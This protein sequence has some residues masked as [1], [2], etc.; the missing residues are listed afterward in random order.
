MIYALT[1][2]Q[3]NLL[4]EALGVPDNI[5]VAAEEFYNI[6]MEDFKSIDKTED[7]YKFSGEVDI[8]LGNKNKI[9]IEEY[10][11]EINV[12]TFEKFDKPAQVSS[13]GMNQSFTFD[14]KILMKKISPSKIAEFSI[15]FVANLDWNY[16]E[17]YD[18]FSRNKY[19]Y[20]SSLAH[21]LKHKYDK[22][23]KQIDLIG[24]DAEYISAQRTPRFNIDVIDSKF[25]YYLYYTN[26]AENLVRTT[27]VSSEL[28]SKNISKSEFI[29]FLKKN[30]TFQTL[31][32]IK[33]FTFEKLVDGIRE[34]MTRVDEIL[35]TMG[36]E[37]DEMTDDEKINLILKLIYVNIG[38]VRID[39]FAEFTR[40]PIEG[41]F[42]LFRLFG[43]SP[44]EEDDDNFEEIKNK[45]IKKIMRYDE[46]H[47]DFF[48]DEIK[49]FNITADKMIRK[50][51]KLY[52]M[53][54]KK[55]NNESII[56]WDL[57]MRLMEKKYGKINIKTKL[58]Y[59]K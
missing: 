55:V 26:V 54:H 45:F 13:M 35:T 51:S 10:T 3:Y 29:D 42:D 49:K 33:N 59:I 21:E 44:P 22:Q 5:L 43:G 34:E 39:A 38:S 18:E 25:I 6:F 30:K 14:R 53:T 20:I 46:R 19:D 24:H 23:V 48:K 4:S 27:E 15:N 32:D 2:Q 40:K 37:P 11:L 9:H 52:D 17:L 12:N 28:R 36:K 1:N 50:L 8:T 7:N 31:V 47:V 56:N 41:L 57:H 16:N 58:D